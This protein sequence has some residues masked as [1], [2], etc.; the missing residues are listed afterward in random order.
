MLCNDDCYH[1][2]AYLKQMKLSMR[3]PTGT[4][5][6]AQILRRK[7]CRHLRPS[8]S[9]IIPAQASSTGPEGTPRLDQ[10]RDP[11]VLH[12]VTLDKTVRATQHG[13]L[14]VDENR[15]PV[16]FSSQEDLVIDA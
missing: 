15:L 14:A 6:N 8:H 4:T 9:I 13:R 11:A 10:I 3:F 2:D 1:Q 16:A 12:L 7:L 5:S